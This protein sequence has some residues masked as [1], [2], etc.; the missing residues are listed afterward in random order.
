MSLQSYMPL[1]IKDGVGNM[2]EKEENVPDAE[3]YNAAKKVN[4]GNTGKIDLPRLDVTQFIGKKIP[5]AMVEEFEGE[6]GYY[7]KVSTSAV[8]ELKKS[9]G[10]IIQ[11][12]GSRNF[13][14]QKD[15]EGRIGWGDGTK[16]DLFL[17]KMKVN[18]YKEL[19]GKEVILQTQTSK[20]DGKDYLTF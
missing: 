19:V 20:R 16:L 10:S 17:N 7:I 8:T 11:I 4:L 9:D 14:L 15:E 5:I 18:H 13:S 6:F 2:K 1:G 3:A 12:C